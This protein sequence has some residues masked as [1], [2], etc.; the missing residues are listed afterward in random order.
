MR[1]CKAPVSAL[2]RYIYRQL[3]H[4]RSAMEST[5]FASKR[6][7]QASNP[8]RFPRNF[9]VSLDANQRPSN[10][11][12]VIFMPTMTFLP[13]PSLVIVQRRMTDRLP[14]PLPSLNLRCKLPED[15]EEQTQ[16]PLFFEQLLQPGRCHSQRTAPA[17]LQQ[18]AKF[19]KV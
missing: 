16:D 12:R 3:C 1:R 19:A 13:P 5:Q 15:L 11:P 7:F 10:R 6:H 2:R 14:P 4:L 17:L 9:F 18:R 8:K